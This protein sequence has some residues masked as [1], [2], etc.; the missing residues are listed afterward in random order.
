MAARSAPATLT[1]VVQGPPT[2]ARLTFVQRYQA[3]VESTTCSSSG[4]HQR[5]T[6]QVTR[7][8]VF[9]AELNGNRT[10]LDVFYA[11]VKSRINFTDIVASPLLRK[12]AGKHHAGG[13]IFGFD[14]AQAPGSPPVGN[15]VARAGYDKFL[16]WIWPMRRSNDARRPATPAGDIPPAGVL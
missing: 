7:P 10:D 4:C 14:S 8:P 3:G 6:A 5:T 15:P 9:F 1:L 2:T 16:H 11:Q 13:E 12:P